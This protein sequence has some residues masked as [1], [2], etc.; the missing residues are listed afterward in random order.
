MNRRQIV[1]AAV[2]AAVSLVLVGCG[3]KTPQELKVGATSG[4]HAAI[5][6]EAAK[7]AA[8][9]GLKVKVVEFTDYITPNRALADKALDVNVYQH[10]P[11]LK[12]FNK[13]QNTN[14]VKV[15]D[16]VVQ[17]MGLYSDTVKSLEAVPEGAKI[18]IPNDPT[19]GGRALVLLKAAGLIDLKPGVTGTTATVAD[20]TANPKAVKV[21]ELEAAQLPRSLE[22]V[23]VACVPMNYAISGKLSPEKQGFYFESREAPF[24]LMVIAARPDNAEAKNVQAFVKAYQSPEVKAF[25]EKTF[26]GA[27]KAAW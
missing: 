4:P 14:L 26:N 18:A 3:D 5:V 17:P 21:V 12:N 9:S 7:V 20:I 6:A 8:K 23:D 10:E 19:N 16:A 25:I 1:S 22:D 2:A 13:N 11:F 27:V 15:A 24:A